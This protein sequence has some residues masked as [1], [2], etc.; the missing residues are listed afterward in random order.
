MD[1]KYDKKVEDALA[2]SI[3]VDKPSCLSTNTS[4]RTHDKV[5]EQNA[6]RAKKQIKS[7]FTD[8]SI[9]SVVKECSTSSSTTCHSSVVS[10]SSRENH[11]DDA[12]VDIAKNINLLPGARVEVRWDVH[13]EDLVDSKVVLKSHSRWWG[14]T[15][16]ESDGQTHILQEECDEDVD[17]SDKV[18]V[19]K[20]VLNYDP[21]P[22]GGFDKCSLEDVCFLTD[23]LVLNIDSNE[24]AYWRREGDSWDSSKIEGKNEN[25]VVRPS[26][27]VNIEDD[28]ILV[29]STSREEALREI[30]DTVLKTALSKSG[31][32]NKMKDLPASQKCIVAEKIAGAKEKLTQKLM[33]QLRSDDGI[34]LAK[35]ITPDHV[36][37]C[38][39]ELGKELNM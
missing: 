12:V 32:M 35:V 39:E 5:N 1:S 26:A 37:K 6:T 14:A 7:N 15:L 13:H 22:S 21:F 24:Q 29:E 16:L 8:N 23:H 31:V 27:G 4:K 9:A 2:G 30:L 38:M 10:S 28:G 3:S 36:R 11:A 20:R 25:L 17:V 34:N 18:T 19:A 33:E